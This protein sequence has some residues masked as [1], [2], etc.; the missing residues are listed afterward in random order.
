MRPNIVIIND[1]FEH[2]QT[3]HSNDSSYVNGELAWAALAYIRS[4]L[5]GTKGDNEV[6]QGYYPW[7]TGWN[8]ESPRRSLVKAAAFIA[9]ELERLD[10]D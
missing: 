9:S 3:K 6:A 8:P 4:Y 10:H 5:A 2:Q 7:E 1:E